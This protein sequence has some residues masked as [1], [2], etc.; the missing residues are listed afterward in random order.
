LPPLTTARHSHHRSALFHHQS[1]SCCSQKNLHVGLREQVEATDIAVEPGI[2][3]FGTTRDAISRQTASD[4][5][6]GIGVLRCPNPY[7]LH[8][9]PRSATSVVLWLRRRKKRSKPSAI[10]FLQME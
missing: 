4:P 5:S 2:I 7:T 3:D 10:R 6:R 9:R 1:Y 8:H